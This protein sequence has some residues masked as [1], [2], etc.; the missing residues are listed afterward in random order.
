M[1]KLLTTRTQK[2]RETQARTRAVL[3]LQ[4][5]ATI[6][7]LVTSSIMLPFYAAGLKNQHHLRPNARVGSRRAASS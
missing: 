5:K 4:P 6:Q 7:I 1:K 3:G 2:M